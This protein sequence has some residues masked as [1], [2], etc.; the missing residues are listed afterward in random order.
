MK[1]TLPLEKMSVEEKIRTMEAIWDDLCRKAD[2]ISS[3]SWHE[4]VLVER[5]E[6]IEKGEEEFADWGSAKKNISNKIS[7]L[8][9]NSRGH[10]RSLALTLW[11]T[12]KAA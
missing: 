10:G 7:C 1:I 12:G 5:E 4:D 2:S 8:R 3:P 9:E 11:K 6:R